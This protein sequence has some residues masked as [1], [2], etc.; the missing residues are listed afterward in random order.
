MS[1]ERLLRAHPGPGLNGHCPRRP[2]HLCAPEARSGAAQWPPVA[3]VG[4]GRP[5]RGGVRSPFLPSGRAGAAAPLAPGLLQTHGRWRRGLQGAL[6]HLPAARPPGSLRGGDGAPGESREP[7]GKGH[8]RGDEDRAERETPRPQPHPCPGPKAR[9]HGGSPPEGVPGLERHEVKALDGSGQVA[10]EG[11]EQ[12]RDG[13]VRGLGGAGS[14][15]EGPWGGGRGG[16][17]WGGKRL[18]RLDRFQPR[19]EER[20]PSAVAACTAQP[21]Y[22]H[23]LR[24]RAWPMACTCG[25][26]RR[27]DVGLIGFR[28]T[29]LS[30]LEPRRMM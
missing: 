14:L 16:V 19:T 8:F 6:L 2:C 28:R 11:R 1:T 12:Q 30:R 27:R 26:A 22:G 24:W 17:C 13:D 5:G 23:S 29:C 9:T 25:P 15:R 4:V 10:P 21:S 3:V 20:A 7:P 18:R